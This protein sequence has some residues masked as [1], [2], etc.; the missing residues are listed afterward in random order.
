MANKI[1]SQTERRRAASPSGIEIDYAASLRRLER[2]VT[3]LHNGYVCD[4]W[5]VDEGGAEKALAYLQ[6]RAGG[7]P[8]DDEAWAATI[9]FLDSHN[10]SLDWVFR[11][12]PGVMICATAAH[13]KR[14]REARGPT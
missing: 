9:A 1:R 14:A 13:S 12:E 7:A 4:G 6:S 2:I 3:T 5:S 10:Q 8:D 11:G